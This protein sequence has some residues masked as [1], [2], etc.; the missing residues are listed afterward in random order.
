M[1]RV[2]ES[3]GFVV[4]I[5][6]S[7]EAALTRTRAVDFDVVLTDISMPGADGIDLLRGLRRD[8]LDTPVIL[9]TGNP[10]LAT[11]IDGIEYGAFR[12]LVK[13]VDRG[14]LSAAVRQ[15]A[16]MHA[17]AQIR[18]RVMDLIGDAARQ[19]GD[20]AGLE[21]RFQAA[22]RELYVVHQPIISSARG[23]VLGFEALMRSRE[24]ALSTPRA[25]L[26]AA[27]RLGRMRDLSR[28]LRVHH[29]GSMAS[30]PPGTS[31]FVNLHPTDLLD[32]ALFA[33]ADPLRPYAGRIVFEIT[34]R[35]P[36]ER[37]PAVRSRVADLRALGYRI[38]VDDVGAGYAGLSSLAVL[39]PN[40]VKLDAILVRGIDQS[41]TLQTLIESLVVACARL[42]ID[43]IAEAVETEAE[44]KALED[45]GVDLMQGHLF[46]HA[47]E[48][49]PP[50]ECARRIVSEKSAP[51]Q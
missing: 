51:D 47:L 20:L 45:L 40:I 39:C 12:Y 37:L 44:R 21:V 15:A 46:A 48:G 49:F 25:L 41:K 29:A 43:V 4:D 5:V 9:V 17:V 18:R 31:L 34:E 30:L 28:A 42:Q 24:P 27:E 32:E 10:N 33:E 8:N 3:E 2:L 36:L 13:P 26:L 22:L 14:Q 35:A 1:G 16:S 19:I 6:E 23:V 11:A 38:A 50:A 7:S